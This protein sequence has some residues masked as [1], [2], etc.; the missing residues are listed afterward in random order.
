MTWALIKTSLRSTIQKVRE[1]KFVMFDEA[2]DAMKVLYDGLA[3]EI[4]EEF[5]RIG[6]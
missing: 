4:V 2:Q 5:Q 6:D 3:N 1:A